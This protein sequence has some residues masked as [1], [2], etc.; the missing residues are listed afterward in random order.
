MANDTS[1]TQ[2]AST[3]EHIKNPGRVA[4]GKKLARMSKEL[5]EKKKARHVPSARQSEIVKSSEKIEELIQKD[6]KIDVETKST[7]DLHRIEVIVGIGG[8][9]VAAAALYL[10][11]KSNKSVPSDPSLVLQGPSGGCQ[12]RLSSPQTNP[13]WQSKPAEQSYDYRN[14]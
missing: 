6:I 9:I 2:Q 14:F 13:T 8:L 12:V 7:L 1:S 3:V 10:N 4:W 5:K 11:Y